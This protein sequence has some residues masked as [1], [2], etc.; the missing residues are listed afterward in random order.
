MFETTA[1]DSVANHY[2]NEN[3]GTATAG[4]VIDADD[5][6]IIQDELTAAVES[7]EQALDPTG[8]IRDQLARAMAILGGSASS[9]IDTG[10]VNAYVVNPVLTSMIKPGSYTFMDGF[11]ITFDVNV[12]NT[13]AS[14]LAY[15]GLS[16]KSI[17]TRA[18]A[19]IAAAVMSETV[20]LIYNLAS[21]RWEFLFSSVT[22]AGGVTA[23]AGEAGVISIGGTASIPEVGIFNLGIDTAKINTGAVTYAK[24]DTEAIN[25][26][27]IF[28]IAVDSS[29]LANNA[30]TESRILS[31]AVTTLKI[32]VGAVSEN[33]LGT[34]AVTT[35]KLSNSATDALN[36]HKRVAK[37]WVNI[38]GPTGA[39]VNSF[40]VSSVSRT[41]TGTYTVNFTNSVP[42]DYSAVVSCG[43]DDVAGG[44]NWANVH[45]LQA[46]SALIQTWDFTG[47]VPYDSEL[48]CLVIMAD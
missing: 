41:G 46:N 45:N 24:M 17:T 27:N 18:G 31:G 48:I 1:S 5:R 29:K 6:N 14:T 40:N 19:A 20:W 7:S 25:T 21:D 11:I 3:L 2:V 13:G 9:S 16:A 22:A 12:V 42:T 8:V 4:T 47:G 10:A 34:G 39:V 36:V 26:E 32:G 37:A 33:R 23:V 28:N 30:V 43:K 35:T 44:L 38:F 15:G